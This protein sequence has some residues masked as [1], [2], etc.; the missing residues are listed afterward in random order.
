MSVINYNAKEIHCKIIYYGIPSAGKTSNIKWI[1]QN[2]ASK[3]KLDLLSF[4]LSTKPSTFFDFLPL[5]IGNIYKFKTRVHLYSLPSQ[6]LFESSQKLLFKGVDG[7]IFVADSQIDKMKANKEH[8]HQL[9][10]QL[11]IEGLLLEKIPMAL[12]YNKRDLSN[13][14]SISDMRVELNHFNHPDF[15][16]IAQTGQGVFKSLKTVLKMLISAFKG[17]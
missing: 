16:A 13:I 12:Q 2:T 6:S 1:Y 3:K 7:V 15:P 17:K 4:S 10:K 9:Q 14:H 5:D 11:K 8:L